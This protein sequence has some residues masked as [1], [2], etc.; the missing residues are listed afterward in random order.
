VT[1][2]ST[3]PSTSSAFLDSRP[4]LHAETWVYD[5]SLTHVV[6]VEHPWRG[7]VPPGAAVE[8]GE[9][10][11]AAAL[12]ALTASTGLTA[13][14]LVTP[15]AATARAY[16]SGTAPTLGLAFAAVVAGRPALT[17]TAGRAPV[18]Q[19]LDADWGPWFP[20]DAARIRD[21]ARALQN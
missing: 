13:E 11:R 6:L 21:T 7:L 10:P 2:P 8:P 4:P 9:T 18:W 15:A 16:R 5:E 19:P 12:R 3:E 1:T 20:D 14:L 17:D